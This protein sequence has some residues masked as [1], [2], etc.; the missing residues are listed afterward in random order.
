MNNISSKLI[1]KIIFDIKKDGTRS[2][3]ATCTKRSEVSL[4][5]IR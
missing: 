4:V 2:I 3:K 1:C 5:I